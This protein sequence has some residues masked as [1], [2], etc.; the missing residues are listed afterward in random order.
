MPFSWDA[1]IKRALEIKIRR[2]KTMAKNP[3]DD[4]KLKHGDWIVEAKAN[5]YDSLIKRITQDEKNRLAIA[6]QRRAKLVGKA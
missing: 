4:F 5:R 6:M 2:A 1:Q 3:N